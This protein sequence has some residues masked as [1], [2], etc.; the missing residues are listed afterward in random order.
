MLSPIGSSLAYQASLTRGIA[1]G[2]ASGAADTPSAPE[3]APA[4]TPDSAPAGAAVIDDDAA[5]PSDTAS[6]AV[7]ISLSAE[8]QLTLTTYQETKISISQTSSDS[9]ASNKTASPPQDPESAKALSTLEAIAQSERDWIA[10]LKAE[11]EGKDPNKV[12]SSDSASNASKTS[13]KTSTDASAS[14]TGGLQVS[15]EQDTEVDVSL[16]VSAQISAQVDIQ[17]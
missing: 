16:S 1:S 14:Q 4:N 5:A 17:A 6:P 12:Q 7:Q 8:A 10:K 2:A 9:G 13:A 3:N 11:A 15:I